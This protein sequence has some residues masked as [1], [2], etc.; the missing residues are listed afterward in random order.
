MIW[1]VV[2][3]A[4]SAQPAKQSNQLSEGLTERIVTAVEQITPGVTIDQHT[5]HGTIRKNGH[6]FAYLFLG[7]LTMLACRCSG[8]TGIR[9]F[10]VTVGICVL[11][12]ILD[13][14]HQQFVPGRS[15][16]WADIAIDSAGACMGMMIYAMFMI[17]N[18]FRIA[19]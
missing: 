19:K 15:A 4:L 5:F 16:Q 9:A 11:Y 8:M 18:K 1:M 14:F 7:L 2:I 6:F 10:L 13:E 17:L 12:A 3:F